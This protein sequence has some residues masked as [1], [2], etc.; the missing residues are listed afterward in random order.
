MKVK[1]IRIMGKNLSMEH[2][3]PGSSESESYQGNKSENYQGNESE[4]YQEKNLSMEHKIPGSSEGFLALA[5]SKAHSL[6]T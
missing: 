4:S 6:S 3:I 2:K 1:V 5:A